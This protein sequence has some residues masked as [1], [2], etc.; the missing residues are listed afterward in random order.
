MLFGVLSDGQLAGI[1]AHDFQ[2]CRMTGG[3]FD[4]ISNRL[5]RTSLHGEPDLMRRGNR[6]QFRTL[7]SIRQKWSAG[8]KDS[9]K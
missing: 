8:R 7:G 3:P 4:L 6:M 5:R 9:I 2:F 1:A